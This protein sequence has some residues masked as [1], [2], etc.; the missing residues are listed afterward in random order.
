MQRNFL[1]KTVSLSVLTVALFS[2]NGICA[3]TEVIAVEDDEI[4]ETPTEIIEED[5]IL[6][7]IIL[8]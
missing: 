6:E 1:F 2:M 7:M 3:Q 8:M 5:D 4:L